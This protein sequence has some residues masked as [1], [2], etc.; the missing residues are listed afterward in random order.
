MQERIGIKQLAVL[1]IFYLVGETLWFMPSFSAEAAG[2]DGWIS[3]LIGIAAGL[4]VAFFIYWFSQQFPG[5]SLV[6]VLNQVLGRWAGGVAVAFVLLFFL[7]NAATQVREI[8]DFVT[9][10]IMTETPLRMV[11]LLFAITVAMGLRSGL[12][13]IAR[14][15]EV[16]F[17]LFALTVFFLIVLLI[18]HM[19]ISKL[20]PVMNHS[21]SDISE[22]VLYFVAFPFCELIVFLM[23][24]P[25]VIQKGSMRKDYMV[26]VFV[27]AAAMFVMVFIALSVLGPY[28]TEHHLYAT[29][30]MV[31]KINIGDFLQRV[32]VILVVGFVLSTYFKCVLC[33]YAFAAGLAEWLKLRAY[34]ALAVPLCLIMYGYS[35]IISPNIVFFNS[36]NFYWALL[37]LTM[38]PFFLILVIVLAK[39]R[40]HIAKG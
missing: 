13:A 31:K 20:Q 5:K 28:M 25:A 27:G 7:N 4:A 21:F 15:S 33:L 8:G 26:S 39:L 32:E 24:F 18:P 1:V 17:G 30:A 19:D 35:Y 9:T 16:F 10:Q 12:A 6:G 3:C 38:V 2:Q 22:G 40:G 36:M 37:D 34:G 14:T 11:N 29:Y 23:V